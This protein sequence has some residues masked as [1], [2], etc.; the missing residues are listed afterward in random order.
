MEMAGDRKPQKMGSQEVA[1]CFLDKDPCSLFSFCFWKA[2]KVFPQ[3][4]AP[5]PKEKGRHFD[6]VPSP[7]T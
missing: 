1:C 5:S 2:E 6:V 3:S 7:P 4:V